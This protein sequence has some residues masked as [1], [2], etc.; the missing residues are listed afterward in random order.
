M[1][2]PD[3]LLPALILL[4]AV[5][6]LGLPFFLILGLQLNPANEAMSIS[7]IRSIG[8]MVHLQCTPQEHSEGDHD[9]P[10]KQLGEDH[11]LPHVNLVFL[12]SPRCERVVVDKA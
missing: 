8:Q 9:E 12:V 11:F 5:P 4:L 10:Q 7:F 2:G 1:P 6:K 3:L